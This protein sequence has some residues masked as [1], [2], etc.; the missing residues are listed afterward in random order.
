MTGFLMTQLVFE[1]PIFEPPCDKSYNLD[2]TSSKDS[3]QLGH[4]ASVISL[5]CA[6][7]EPRHE[8]TGFLHMRKQTQISFAVAAKLI[9]AFVFTT[10]TEFHCQRNFVFCSHLLNI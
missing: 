9:S 8:K 10:Y 7:N 5:C 3:D 6:L 4:P 1:P 2:F